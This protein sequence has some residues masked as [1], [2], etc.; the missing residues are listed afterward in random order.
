MKMTL[1][2]AFVAVGLLVAP[3]WS[4]A[5]DPLQHPLLV[6]DE[7]ANGGSAGRDFV[8]RGTALNSDFVHVW[9]FPAGSA[10]VWFGSATPF[11]PDPLRQIGGGVFAVKVTGAP[12]GNYYV[13]IYAHEPATNT[14]P[15]SV[16]IPMS[17]HACFWTTQA[18]PFMGAY[19]LTTVPLPYCA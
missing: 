15:T 14:F 10:P 19:G 17:V 12:V 4:E 3:V 13:S 8:I 1:C 16:A 7:P 6:I 18:W 2:A 9:A 11:A 5:Q